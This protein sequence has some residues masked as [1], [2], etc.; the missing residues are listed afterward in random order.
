MKIL[1]F[2]L[3]FGLFM[4]FAQEKKKSGEKNLQQTAS[5]EEKLQLDI[6][7]GEFMYKPMGRRDPFKNLLRGKEPS[8]RRGEGIAGLTIDEFVL[9][10][11]VFG[12]GEYRAYVKSPDNLPYTLKVGDNVYNGK[13][14]EINA[15][16]VIFKQILTVALG[17]TKEKT[18]TKY[19]NPEEEA[20]KK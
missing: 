15:G 12:N 11:I 5:L 2:I 7:S 19:L 6:D 1:T 3:V 18:V 9:E 10:G 4:G 20:K 14:I 17:G 13:V 16:A 8:S